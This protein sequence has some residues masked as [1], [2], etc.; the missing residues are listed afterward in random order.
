M[1]VFGVEQS[2]QADGECCLVAFAYGSPQAIADIL[3][4]AFSELRTVTW[5]GKP[6]ERYLEGFKFPTNLVLDASV[7][8]KAIRATGF[9]LRRPWFDTQRY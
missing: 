4:E 3:H 1:I 9:R 6:G 7:A 5:E 8:L 2:G